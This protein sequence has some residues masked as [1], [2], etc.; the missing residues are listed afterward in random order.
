MVLIILLL[1]LVQARAHDPSGS[2]Y[3]WQDGKARRL[4]DSGAVTPIWSP[5]GQSICY[6]QHIHD[7][8]IFRLISPDGETLKTIPLPPPL[9]VT[10]G[11]SWHPD[12]AEIAFA[13]SQGESFDIYSLNLEDGQ[14][15]LIMS[16]GIHPA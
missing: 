10:G 2:V 1:L 5:D 8:N 7:E 14:A 11:M 13:A 6:V 15:E 9:T 16:D 4:S 3:C 12:G